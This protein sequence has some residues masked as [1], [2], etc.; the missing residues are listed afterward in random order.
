MEVKSKKQT[1][2]GVARLEA[3]G[4]I[5]EV[6]I[7]EDFLKPSDARISVCFRGK[8]SSGIVELTSK[9]LEGLYKETK[10]RLKLFKGVKMFRFDERK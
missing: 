1:Y 3:F 10:K 8:D 2:S 9:E 4:E 6:V 7:N 5:K